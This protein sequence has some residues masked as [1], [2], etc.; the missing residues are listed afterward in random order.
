MTT[1]ATIERICLVGL[2]DL[3][4]RL[5]LREIVRQSLG[6]E[7]SATRIAQLAPPPRR[8]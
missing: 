3:A 5:F 7:T 2:F 6:M 1:R 8:L 4:Y